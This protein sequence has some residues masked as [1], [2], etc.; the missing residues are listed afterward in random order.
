MA[1]GECFMSR[2]EEI[3]LRLRLINVMLRDK[4]AWG[5]I[6]KRLNELNLGPLEG[7]K[8]TIDSLLSFYLIQRDI[9]K[10]S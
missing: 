7:G 4:L 8:W 2:D 10:D 6:A 3:G 5:K 1:R 9:W